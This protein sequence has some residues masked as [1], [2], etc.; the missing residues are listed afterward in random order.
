MLVVTG[1]AACATDARWNDFRRTEADLQEAREAGTVECIGQEA[2][3]QAWQRTQQYVE[4]NSATRTGSVSETTIRTEEPHEF[5]VVYLWAM[6]TQ[7][8]GA[9]GRSRISLKGMCRGMYRGDGG[10]GWLY[11]NCAEQLRRVEE[12]FRPFVLSTG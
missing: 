8:D 11:Q 3:A 6:R 4:E 12:N 9:G 7:V 5:G 10:P 2:C 1:I